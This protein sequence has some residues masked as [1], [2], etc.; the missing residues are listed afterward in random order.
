MKLSQSAY[1]YNKFSKNK[2]CSFILISH[3]KIF[4]TTTNYLIKII[5][6]NN[7]NTYTL[8]LNMIK[9]MN[10]YYCYSNQCIEIFTDLIDFL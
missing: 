1:Y 2:S 7:N 6:S 9:H 4:F 5:D 8:I 10:L 3:F